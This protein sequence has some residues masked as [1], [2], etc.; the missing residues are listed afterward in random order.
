MR[1][2]G[3][4]GGQPLF[5]PYKSSSYFSGTSPKYDGTS[6]NS[7]NNSDNLTRTYINKFENFP[8]HVKPEG[9]S[10][11]RP[12]RKLSPSKYESLPFPTTSSPKLATKFPRYFAAGGR[13]ELTPSSSESHT[14]S[15]MNSPTKDH[16]YSTSSLPSSS[17]GGGGG[18]PYRSLST[19]FSSL[20][21]LEKA[22][23]D[24]G[25]G[26]RFAGGV[27][28]RFGPSSLTSSRPDEGSGSLGSSSPRFGSSLSSNY[29]SPSSASF[30][31]LARLN[32]TPVK[33][34]AKKLSAL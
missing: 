25:S 16:G 26:T 27:W 17:G 34:R 2:T 28:N 19:R 14:P 13:T 30:L 5:S 6:S 9:S 22:N 18:S 33:F 11:E 23:D 4:E 8:V 12:P 31:K 1:L 29:E 15:G 24:S 10:P 20:P 7:P 32:L 21:P 3:S